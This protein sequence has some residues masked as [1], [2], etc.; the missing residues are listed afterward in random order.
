MGWVVKKQNDKRVRSY[1]Q[2]AVQVQKSQRKAGNPRCSL[3]RTTLW[4]DDWLTPRG[5]VLFSK[6]KKGEY[7]FADFVFLGAEQGKVQPQW[8]KDSYICSQTQLNKQSIHV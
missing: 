5:I 7:L 2:A 3:K 8:N 4:G 1:L 6:F